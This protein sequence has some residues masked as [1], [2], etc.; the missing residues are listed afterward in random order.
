M[1]Q[2]LQQLDGEGCSRVAAVL[3]SLPHDTV[4]VVGQAHSYVSH[5]FDVVDVVHKRQGSSFVQ[6]MA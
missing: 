3:R 2:V 5:V 1:S 4:L 6:T